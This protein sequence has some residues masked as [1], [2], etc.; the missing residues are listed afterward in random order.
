MELKDL[1][2]IKENILSK[3]SF[4]IF[5]K[6]SK[7]ILDYENASVIL[8]GNN[9]VDKKIRQVKTRFLTNTNKETS[10]TN[11]YWYKYLSFKFLKTLNEMYETQKALERPIHMD[12]TLSLLKYDVG[13]FYNAHSDYHVTIPRRI[14]FIYGLND[15]YEGGE[16]HFHFPDDDN[17]K[18]KI[19]SNS[20]IIFPSNHLFV[21]SV[22]KVTKGVRYVI[23][24]WM[25]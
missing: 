25:P 5:T 9:K 14:S 6:V 1:V 20:L 2:F 4:N 24:G 8:N 7:E 21:H 3:K 23:V 10:F 19:K 22:A 16:L 12:L 13:A 17:N 15:D 18:I 11:V